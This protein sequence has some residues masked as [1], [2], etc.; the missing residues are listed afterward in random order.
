MQ[1]KEFAQSARSPI[2]L[3]LGT[4][5]DWASLTPSRLLRVV[6]QDLFDF[7]FSLILMTKVMKP[8]VS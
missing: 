4:E 1:D 2:R 6:N 5:A 3:G 7:V 8:M